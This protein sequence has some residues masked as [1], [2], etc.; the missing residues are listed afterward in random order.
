[1]LPLSLPPLTVVGIFAFLANW[2]DF[3][4]PLIFIQSPEKTVAALG[5]RSMMDASQRGIPWNLIMTAS[6]LLVLPC[7]IAL[8]IGQRYFVKGIITSGLAGR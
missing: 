3:L 8:L 7:L 4:Y 5:V 1:M 6:F 2:N